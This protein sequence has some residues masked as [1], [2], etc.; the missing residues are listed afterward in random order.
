MTY[1]DFEDLI[2]ITV[3]DKILCKSAFNININPKYDG[4]QHGIASMIYRF[5]DNKIRS[6]TLAT[7]DKSAAGGTI[8][9]E[10]MS[11]KE[12]AK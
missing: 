1:G 3:S 5:F 12:F 4:Y 9:N 2:R 6:E 8:K 7:P 10:H 11:N